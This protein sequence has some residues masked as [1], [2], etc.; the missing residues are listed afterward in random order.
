MKIACL[1]LLI[2]V[3]SGLR[4]GGAFAQSY[5][6][7]HYQ[8]E[9]GLS[10]NAVLCS[11]QDDQGF[12]W[13]G[14]KDGLNRFNGY[15]F[16]VFRYDDRVKGSIGSNFI[17]TLCQD[18][19]GVLWA[20]TDKG[21]YVFDAA[22]ESFALL[23]GTQHQEIRDIRVDAKGI[24]WFIADSRV[25]AYDPKKGGYLRLDTVRAFGATAIC[26]TRE[27]ELW[28]STVDGLLERY[29]YSTGKFETRTV[30]PN[31]YNPDIN[32]EVIEKIYPGE[33]HTLFIGTVNKGIKLYDTRSGKC[34]DLIPYNK[35]RSE[36]YVRDI[37]L[38]AP[39][40]YWIATE[41]GIKIYHSG[42]NKVVSLDKRLNDPY[43]LSDN[44]VYTLCMD[45]EGGIWCGTYF[46]GVNFYPRRSTRF[47]LYFPK[48]GENSISGNAVRE[49]CRDRLGNLWVGTED[50]GLNEW[51][52]G[53]EGWIHYMPG[54]PDHK[55]S[56][57]NI[58]GLLP[59]SNE[60]WVGTFEHGLDVLDIATGRQKRH[61]RAGKKAGT[62]FSNF[63]YC[64]GRTRN[65]DV[66]VGT[67]LGLQRYDRQADSWV[68]V[69][70]VSGS[71]FVT[72]ILEDS[73]GLIWVCT[74]RD[75]LYY[76]D[77][78][79]GENGRF[80]YGSSML[81]SDHVNSITEDGDHRLWV[82]TEGG[83][84]VYDPVSK[85]VWQ[86]TVRSGLP[87]D[88]IYKIL[89]DDQGN[90]WIS[91]SRG[92]VFME[93]SSGSIHVHTTADGLLNDQ[94][95]Y[96]SGFKD[97]GDTLYFGS[98]KG[99]IRFAPGKRGEPAFHAPVYITGMQ[100]LNRELAIDSAA[101]P[102]K[103][104]IIRTRAIVLEHGQNSFSLDFAA[105]SYLSP[106]MTGYMYTLKGFDKDWT[107][108]KTNRRI[109]YT[110]LPPG[111]YTFLVKAAENGKDWGAGPAKLEIRILPPFWASPLAYLVYVCIGSGILY[112][113]IRF[114]ITRSRE[115]QRRRNELLENEKQKELYQAKIEFFTN[116]AHE[117]KTP[118]TMI[119]LPLEKI[120]RESD[121]PEN[122]SDNL[123]IMEKNTNR[124]I[125][126]TNQLLD[127]RRTEKN[128]FSLNFV[129]SD[130]GELLKEIASGFKPAAEEQQL[131]LRVEL[132]RIPFQA[133]VDPEAFTK[134]LTNLVG[135]AVKYAGSE[136]SLGIQPFSSND[137]HFTIRIANDGYLIPEEAREHI[138]E[139]F[140][141]LKGTEKQPGTGIGLALV[142]TLTEL[143]KGSVH[144]VTEGN[145]NVF[146]L[147]LP[148][149]QEK[150]F[151]FYSINISAPEPDT[152]QEEMT[153]E[154][155]DDRPA[156]LLV[157]DNK[158]ILDFEA[159]QLRENY[160]VYLARNGEEAIA[161]LNREVVHLVISDIMMPVMDGLELCRIIKSNFEYS[162]IPVI[163]L[164]A[165]NTMQSKI[166][167]L[168][169][170]ADSYI[171]KPFSQEYLQAQ[172]HSLLTNRN[173]L[174]QYFASVPMAG[175]HSIAYS[176]SDENF[177]LGIS[178][179]IHRH[180]TDQQFG[181]EQLA[182]LMNMSRPTLY[183]KIKALA[184]MSP[185]ELITVT[186]LKRAAE[187]LTSGDLKIYEIAERVG[188]S[189]ASNFSRD[190][191]RQ[192]SMSPSEYLAALSKI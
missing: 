10:N 29:D 104:S 92:L 139:P 90:S 66:Y 163:L 136:V 15:S 171:E 31:L 140:F 72:S 55:V 69:P 16:K 175:I 36:I 48:Q 85:K 105:L 58:H 107:W 81:N 64:L 59:D 161:I 27:G 151:E 125:E 170:G 156:I 88:V 191:T 19:G 24:V 83:I 114:F 50:A 95:N 82:A 1:T 9:N 142:K 54:S 98:V 56:Y 20:G 164:T 141:R 118:L 134:I 75:G 181:V 63:I 5:Y 6:F 172:I 144:N 121:V 173:K 192:F 168:E 120:T 39:G 96:N 190:F 86:Y 183:R 179:I 100:V 124:L 137:E 155:G 117:I 165:K 128:D 13:F 133:F 12:L 34:R 127:F 76:F 189:E 51:K 143:H 65:G 167:G 169:T 61:Y 71:V 30:E 122:I 157:E 131:H 41:S 153:R 52:E 149:H 176:R 162:H 49:I 38:T 77:P 60:L 187:L 11:L 99:M 110:Q 22:Q 46:G 182:R 152:V 84:V 35:D 184:N 28:V 146:Y 132:P 78:R 166:K 188:Y 3:F 135:N 103:Q 14:T 57:Y 123:R 150:E 185:N 102:L 111:T 40:E 126:L 174:K 119:K 154:P 2:M 80:R 45:R 112:G 42:S 93:R 129:K 4:P 97:R 87:S 113:L 73:R 106:E 148:I 62:L 74:M 43:S 177:L 70:Q 37:L 109:F 158:E 68:P 17:H 138:F 8:V 79:T 47:E 108:L 33:D 32:Q 89:F 67:S 26:P 160:F 44:A 53:A 25:R 147:R 145:K 159:K 18:K 180:L 178:D 101:S 116:I 115:R 21:L 91:T 94:F 23:K 186:R 7:R 130:I